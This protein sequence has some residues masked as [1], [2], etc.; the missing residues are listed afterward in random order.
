MSSP[1]PVVAQHVAFSPE[2]SPVFTVASPPNTVRRSGERSPAAQRGL[3]RVGTP[4]SAPARHQRSASVRT[5]E[6]EFQP[7]EGSPPKPRVRRA[8]SI[9]D[10]LAD[11]EDLDFE[12]PQLKASLQMNVRRAAAAHGHFVAHA[13]AV[14]VEATQPTAASHAL[15]FAFA[16]APLAG[17]VVG[18][19]GSIV[20]ANSAFEKL[21][22]ICAG[23]PFQD[24]VCSTKADA[25]QLRTSLDDARLDGAGEARVAG[26]CLETASET[27]NYEWRF[28]RLDDAGSL[29]V[30]GTPRTGAVSGTTPSKQRGALDLSSL[31]AFRKSPIAVHALSAAG[32]ILFANEAELELLGYAEEEYVGRPISDFCGA[33]ALLDL[34]QTLQKGEDLK[35]APLQLKAKDGRFLSF[36]IDANGFYDASGNFTHT[37]GF[38]RD[39]A[40]RIVKEAC[41][42]LMVRELK[43]SAE[44]FD[45]FVSRTLHLVR[46]P[47]H[48][49]LADLDRVQ[50]LPFNE[51]SSVLAEAATVLETVIGMTADVS[52]MMRFEQGASLKIQKTPTNLVDLGKAAVD[53]ALAL[54]QNKVD[55]SFR[56]E[57]FETFSTDAQVVQ[58]VLT[59]LLKNSAAATCSGTISL[60]VS[61]TAKGVTF[62]VEDQG[63]G[64]E[65]GSLAFLQRYSAD[66][67][68]VEAMTLEAALEARNQLDLDLRL[69]SGT[70]GLGIGLSLAYWLVHALGGELQGSSSLGK[71]ARFWFTL[72]SEDLEAGEAS[73]DGEALNEVYYP[74]KETRRRKNEALAHLAAERATKYAAFDVPDTAK[75]RKSLS[76]RGAPAHARKMPRS[77]SGASFEPATAVL[78]TEVDGRLVFDIDAGGAAAAKVPH[79]LV[80]EDSALCAKVLTKMLAR[81]GCTSH[82]VVDG[83]LAL[84]AL[85]AHASQYDLVLMDL[86]MPVMDGFEATRIAKQKLLIRTP[87]VAVTAES[88]FETQ[89]RCVRVG[90]DDFATKPIRLPTLLELLTKHLDSQVSTAKSR[91]R[92]SS[93]GS[94]LVPPAESNATTEVSDVHRA[95]M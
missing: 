48:V 22:G 3:H 40:G 6:T 27:L 37:H 33:D 62:A 45:A 16:A 52:D 36:L 38:L 68:L 34:F 63:A 8:R 83:A 92:R 25:L 89:E 12:L 5:L 85:G 77:R 71:G 82:V 21:V 54:V 51:A 1:V 64:L 66:L 29:I 11:L 86:R 95:T 20:A 35:S 15:A 74:A 24:V 41:A 7:E 72:P 32:L 75:L 47:C 90:F 43:R 23:R 31:E 30:L 39:D 4:E 84:V 87:I 73:N 57:A 91:S 9:P 94:K 55:L 14:H 2:A 46:T 58:R 93:V 70:E 69:S 79:V 26:S 19:D 13:E 49:V 59:H 42:E 80:V 28:S 18:A 17:C 53:S 78:L 44:L 56:F 67:K 81:A 65:L 50:T 61:S 60:A 88:G 10:K 76:D